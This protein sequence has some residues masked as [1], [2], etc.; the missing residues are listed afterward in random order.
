MNMA[1]IGCEHSHA[2]AYVEAAKK[3]SNI[4]IVGLAE[5]NKELGKAFADK[6]SLKYYSSYQELIDNPEVSVVCICTANIRHCE[7]TIAAAKA[8]KHVIVEKPIATTLEDAERMIEACREN[9]VKLMV[10]LPC[11]YIPAVVRAK[12]VI[13]QGKLGDIVAI[14][15]TN[16]GTMPGGWFVDKELSGGGAI[17]DH[18][19]HVADLIHWFI[20]ADIKTVYAKGGTNYHS[21]PTEDTGLLFMTFDNGT[22]GTL[23]TSW[24]RPDAYPTWGD[25]TMEIVGTKG[26]LFLDSFKQHGNIYSNNHDKSLH[27]YWGNDMNYLMIKDFVE[28]IEE[29]R[30]SPV[31]GEAG[32]FALEVA[33]MAYEAIDKGV[34]AAK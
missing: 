22:Y 8:K 4:N 32:L 12:E 28:A 7:L 26:S 31:P 30:P 5:P 24:N 23:D 17:I 18:T 29:D 11:R 9:G 6:N 14:T 21:I 25:V 33:L 2:S 20:K 27:S 19:I 15:G 3:L 16:H 13:D 34:P 10:A 1:I